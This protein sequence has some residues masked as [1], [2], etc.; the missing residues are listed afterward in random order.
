M[1]R[2]GVKVTE[3]AGAM[4]VRAGRIEILSATNRDYGE[5]TLLNSTNPASSSPPATLMPAVAVQHPPATASLETG[6]PQLVQHDP[7][8]PQHANQTPKMNKESSEGKQRASSN[9]APPAKTPL[10]PLPPPPNAPH[11]KKMSISRKTSKPIINWFQRKLAGTVRTRRASDGDALRNQRLAGTRSPNIK[12]TS[13][14]SSVPSVPPLPGS[15]APRKTKSSKR[16]IAAAKRNTISLDGTDDFSSINDARTVDSSDDYRDSMWSP[17]S[18]READEDASVRPIPPSSP[19]SPSPSH[20]SSSYLSDPRT[21]ASMA[22]STKPTT[23]LSVDLTGGV[24]H[25]AQAPPTPTT[26]SHRLS[27]HVRTHSGNASASGSITFSA[28]PPNGASSRPSSS[29]QLSRGATN[30]NAPQHTTHHPR[31]NPRPASPPLDDASVLTLASSAFGIPGARIGMN[32][33]IGR[34]SMADDSVSHFSGN[35]GL[36]DSTSHFVL[37]EL[38]GEDERMLMEGYRDEVFRDG[39]VDASVRALRP[40]SSRRGSWESEASGWSARISSGVGPHGTPSVLRERSLFT[41]GSYR[42]GGR[43]VDI[44]NDDEEH[45]HER[46]AEGE[47][48]SQY[49]HSMGFEGLSIGESSTAL[50]LELAPE[51]DTEDAPSTP[52]VVDARA[53]S[54]QLTMSS[55][56]TAGETN[57]ASTPG[58]DKCQE[59][60]KVSSKPLAEEPPALPSFQSITALEDGLGTLRVPREQ[61]SV[62]A[63]T[64]IFLSV[65]S[66][67]VSL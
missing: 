50:S 20:S 41:A 4:I 9:R 58:R 31:N 57:G 66:S 40:R 53:A 60:P 14:R 12:E 51:H 36:G 43:S 22:A 59:T 63:S 5:A 7:A 52:P 17:T 10:S 24:A 25:I 64:D 49:T 61:R 47:D 1:R 6:P 18:L 54:P 13:R 28:L 16:S 65:P 55:V 67:P 44:L 30:L 38:D 37:G 27:P 29:A 35:A 19:P 2:P 48:R 3:C 56:Q 34:A 15:Q 23:L 42:T 26:L 33:L 46:H 39:D 21:F 32:A 45:A 8:A 11:M 62:S